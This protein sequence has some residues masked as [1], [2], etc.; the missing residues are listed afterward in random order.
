[1]VLITYVLPWDGGLVVGTV[2]TALASCVEGIGSVADVGSVADAPARSAAIRSSIRSV[3]S[4]LSNN[5]RIDN[6][7]RSTSSKYSRRMFCSYAVI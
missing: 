1:M 3:A 2:A 5:N 7:G 4:A 6:V